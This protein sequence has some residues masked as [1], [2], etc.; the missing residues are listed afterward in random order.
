[1]CHAIDEKTHTQVPKYRPEVIH[2]PGVAEVRGKP[3]LIW[4]SGG[5]L[6]ETV[7]N[8]TKIFSSQSYFIDSTQFKFKYIK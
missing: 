3:N 8:M 1:M 2:Y 4:I 7:S 6:T 5:Y